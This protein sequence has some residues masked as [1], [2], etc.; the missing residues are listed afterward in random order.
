M[1]QMTWG[2]IA[3]GQPEVVPTCPERKFMQLLHLNLN[4][5][6]SLGDGNSCLLSAT[7][8]VSIWHILF[9]LTLMLK[10]PYQNG[11]D[12]PVAQW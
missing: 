2:Y 4:W 10:A 11:A 7:T 9:H 5:E 3:S 8:Y 1:T 12:S 6:N